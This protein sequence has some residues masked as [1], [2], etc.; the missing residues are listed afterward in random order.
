M[1]YWTVEFTY[2]AEATPRETHTRTV[3]AESFDLAR[4]AV[5]IQHLL[6]GD[7]INASSTPLTDS[8]AH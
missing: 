5:I 4:T 2:D 1:R 3:R 8:Y 7:R 6:V